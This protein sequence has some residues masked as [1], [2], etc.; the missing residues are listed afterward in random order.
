MRVAPPE[1]LARR[2]RIATACRR[3][4][5]SQQAVTLGE[6][7]KPGPKAFLVTALEAALAHR[8][9]PRRTRLLHR[10]GFPLVQPRDGDGRRGVH[11]PSTLTGGE[12]EPGADLATARNLGLDGAG[13]TGQSHGAVA[14]GVRA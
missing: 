12:R 9:T 10:A 8:E 6:R 14:W 11:R 1:R 7:A 13:G 3:L 2:P 4:S 5:W